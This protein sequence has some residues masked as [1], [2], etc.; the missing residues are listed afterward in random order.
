VKYS[1]L[2]LFLFT[3]LV[4]ATGQ[5]NIRFKRLTTEEGEDIVGV[6]NSLKIRMATFGWAHLQFD[7]LRFDGRNFRRYGQ[8]QLQTDYFKSIRAW[9]IFEDL[10]KNLWI[11]T[12][13]GALMRYDEKLDRFQVVN[14]SSTSIKSILFCQ[15]EDTNGNFW[16]GS[17]GGGLIRYH[18]ERL[19]SLPISKRRQ[20]IQKHYQI[21][22]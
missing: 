19:R 22:S 3:S 7:L 9:L 15:V 20:I 14:D 2:I 6:Q 1:F 13:A 16:I 10:K 18:P 5:S 8:P 4:F 21:T 12:D 11:G 17:L